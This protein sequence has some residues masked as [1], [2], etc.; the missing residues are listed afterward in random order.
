M[1]SHSDKTAADDF[2]SY[3]WLRFTCLK[4][5]TPG[6]IAVTVSRDA[7]PEIYCLKTHHAM[8]SDMDMELKIT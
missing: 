7:K 4:A 1:L 8:R 5:F 3:T 6:H 2:Y